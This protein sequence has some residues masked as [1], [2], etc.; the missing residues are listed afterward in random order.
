MP[1]DTNHLGVL[2]GGHMLSWMDMA[3]WVVAARAVQPDQRV[4]FK[5]VTDCVWTAPLHAG[6]VC[7]VDAVLGEVGTSSLAVNLVATG[8]DPRRK[9]TWEVCTARFTMVA[10]GAD[11]RPEPVRPA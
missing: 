5:A 11:G 1:A 7:N 3:A 9:A 10:A 4:M 6:E 2:H 8:E